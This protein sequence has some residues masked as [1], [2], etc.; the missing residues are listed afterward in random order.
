MAQA[1]DR[2]TLLFAFLTGLCGN[3]SLAVLTSSYVAFSIFPIIAFA[4]AIASLWQRY[5]EGPLSDN[6]GNCALALF[7]IGAFGYSAFIRAQYPAIGEN[8]LQIF[9]C[10]G[11]SFFVA[12]RLGMAKTSQEQTEQTPAPS[13][14]S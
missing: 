1:I 9:I 4:F 8:L 2:K 11:L 7:F 12:M 13:L 6:T 5:V 10:L 14:E 3:A